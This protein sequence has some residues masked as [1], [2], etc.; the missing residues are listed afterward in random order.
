MIAALFAGVLLALGA[1]DPAPDRVELVDGSVVAGRVVFEDEKRIVVRVRSKER[2]YALAQIRSVRALERSL[3]ELLAKTADGLPQS[4]E[5]RIALAE[6]ARERGLDGE[7]ELLWWSVLALDPEQRDAHLALGHRDAKSGWQY[8][9]ER[10]WQ[11]FASARDAHVAWSDAWVWRTLHYEL[12]ANLALE[13]G[14]ALALD[15]ERLRAAFQVGFGQQLELRASEDRMLAHVHADAK[16]FPEPGAKRSAYYDDSERVLR[17]NAAEGLHRETVFHE[18]THQLL[19]LTAEYGPQAKGVI[20]AWLDEGLAEFMAVAA[21]GPPGGAHFELGRRKLEHYAEHA[22]E[23]DPYDLSRVLAFEA[24]DFM[25]SSRVHLKYAQAYTLVDFLRGGQDGRFRAGF[26]RFVAS[27]YAGQ[28]SS[29]DFARAFEDSKLDER[30]LEK[31]W[32]AWV[33]KIGR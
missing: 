1:S 33:A 3:R 16:S 23:K 14:L 9:S 15:L 11:P 12:R 4:A 8:P 26:E 32:K 7:A 24:S 13:D 18:A 22:R 2:V 20:P 19:H 5:A 21:A 27:A 29:T 30:K 25:T 28:S 10:G 31:E 17:V 6:L